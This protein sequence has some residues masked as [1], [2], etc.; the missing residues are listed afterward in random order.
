M[1][2]SLLDKNQDV[3]VRE[4]IFS[5]NLGSVSFDDA[6]TK[7][8]FF[9]KVCSFVA[10]PVIYLDFD[11]LYSGYVAAGIL[12]QHKNL[13]IHR[14]N[15]NTWREIL[16]DVLERIS[17]RQ[18]LVIVDS[19]NGFF[20]TLSD[21]DSGRIVNSILVLLASLGQ[22]TNSIVL[23]GS[24]S[25]YREGGWII[26]GIGRHVIQIEKMNLFSVKKQNS[27]F[28]LTLV[29]KHNAPKSSLQI[30]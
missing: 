30:T 10:V 8:Y 1:N 16:A 17:T 24:I 4:M 14:P 9:H 2:W 18:H 3:S 12:P 13:E 15:E 25:K 21:K 26:P 6:I 11:L 7:T 28:L 29:D 19:Q 23:A 20:V 5:K 22:K 27:H